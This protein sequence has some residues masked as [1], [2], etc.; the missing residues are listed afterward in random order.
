MEIIHQKE[1]TFLLKRNLHADIAVGQINIV[2]CITTEQ[3][4]CVCHVF[5]LNVSVQL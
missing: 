3:T 1:K 5:I 4:T 2:N